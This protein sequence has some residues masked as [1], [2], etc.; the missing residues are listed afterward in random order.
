MQEFITATLHTAL[1]ARPDLRELG[2]RVGRLGCPRKR[3]TRETLEELT[4]HIF[5]SAYPPWLHGEGLDGYSKI[6][7]IAF[8]LIEAVHYKSLGRSDACDAKKICED[9]QALLDMKR[10]ACSGR[11]VEMIAVPFHWLGDGESFRGRLKSAVLE[12][13][14]KRTRMTRKA[15]LDAEGGGVVV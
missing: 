10:E 13:Q 2:E 14:S 7:A 9:K 4:G 15:E 12:A 11:G 6:L 1:L 8:D 5:P 3:Q